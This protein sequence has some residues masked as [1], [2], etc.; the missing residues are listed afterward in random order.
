M[1]RA[2][3]FSIHPNVYSFLQLS[4]LTTLHYCS[5]STVGVEYTV[6]FDRDLDESERTSVALMLTSGTNALTV[7]SKNI[8]ITGSAEM[9]IAGQ[10]GHIQYSNNL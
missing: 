1:R 2:C 3:V 9:V 7:G 8:Y 10:R 5:Q 6:A 4:H